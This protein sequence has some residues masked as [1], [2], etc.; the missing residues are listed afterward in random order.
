MRCVAVAAHQ[1]KYPN[2]I[3]FEKGERVT[4]GRTDDEYLGWIWTTLSDG[5][6]GWAPEC[7][8]QGEGGDTAIS[9]AAY[10]AVE[11]NTQAGE[12]F[13]SLKELHGWLWVRNSSGSE[14]WVPRATLDLATSTSIAIRPP[15]LADSAQFLAAVEES[16][17]LHDS[18]IH[19]PNS[20][21]NFALYLDRFEQD[22]H[23]SRLVIDR[24][25][26]GIVGVINLNNI[27]RG[28]FQNAFL[29][30]YA[31]RQFA[32]QGLMSEGLRLVVKEAF[33]PLDLHR[34]EANVQPTNERS[35]ALVRRAGFRKEGYSPRYLRI[36]GVWCDHERWALLRDDLPGC[37]TQSFSEERG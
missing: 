25:S 14:G 15:E 6:A 24:E 17:S 20:A 21:E 26:G 23:E 36:A 16:R 33:G 31:F 9:T 1:S 3:A 10:S 30:F 22:D 35:L 28:F 13:V 29:G 34:L 18:W 4:L 27:I 8:L 12:E 5:N 7:L 19:P 37:D 11:L 32:G 2:P